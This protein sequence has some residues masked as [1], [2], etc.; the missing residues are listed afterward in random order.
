MIMRYPEVLQKLLTEID[1]Q[2]T[3]PF[4]KEPKEIERLKAL[5]H[6]AEKKWSEWY[7]KARKYKAVI[8]T[9]CP[10]SEYEIE[11]EYIEGTY[12]DRSYIEYKVKCKCCGEI[13][14]KVADHSNG[15][16]G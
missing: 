12:F 1:S 6:K 15:T 2:P 7:D 13:L 3:K 14:G 4:A 5:Q 11:R 10:H 9:V 16:Y 8:Q